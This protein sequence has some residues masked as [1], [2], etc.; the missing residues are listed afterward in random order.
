MA[1]VLKIAGA[2]AL[3]VWAFSAGMSF[4]KGRDSVRV[5]ASA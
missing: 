4:Q 3:L 5:V 2:I 1:R